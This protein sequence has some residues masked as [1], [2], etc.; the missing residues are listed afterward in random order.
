MLP[1][2]DKILKI[3]LIKGYHDSENVSSMDFDEPYYKILKDG[4]F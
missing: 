1:N 3:L 4:A 2:T